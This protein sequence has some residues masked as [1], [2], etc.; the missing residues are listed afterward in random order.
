MTFT[1]F[2]V[3]GVDGGVLGPKCPTKGAHSF[4]GDLWEGV[5]LFVTMSR[6]WA[7]WVVLRDISW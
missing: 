2:G 4:I 6:L 1:L 7:I 3:A 5:N